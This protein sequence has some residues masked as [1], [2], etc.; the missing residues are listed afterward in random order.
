MVYVAQ[1]SVDAYVEYG[2]HCW[3]IAAAAIIVTEAGGVVLDPT[4]GETEWGCSALSVPI[5]TWLFSGAEFNLMSRKVLCA[6]TEK[7]ARELSG[8]LTHVDYE[9]ECIC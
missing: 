5:V 1:G 8:I 2:L 6:G 9:P 7:L 3:D 4:G